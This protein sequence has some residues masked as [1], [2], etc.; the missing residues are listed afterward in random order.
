MKVSVRKGDWAIITGAIA[1]AVYEK[2]VVDD[3]DLISNRVAA[4]RA[5]P[6]GRLVTDLIIFA[7]ALHLSECLPED[8][9]I[10]HYMMRWIRRTPR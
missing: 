9:D 1:I 6:L 4:Y 10:Y 3:A 7:T 2:T 8:R 5:K